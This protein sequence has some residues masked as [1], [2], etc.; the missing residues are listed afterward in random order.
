MRLQAGRR[1]HPGNDRVMNRLVQ[2]KK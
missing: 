1:Q 2:D